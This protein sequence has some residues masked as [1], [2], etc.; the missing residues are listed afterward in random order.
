MSLFGRP[1]RLYAVYTYLG[2]IS[3]C[4]VL[5]FVV[6]V[7]LNVRLFTYL[8]WMVC[9]HH[10]AYILHASSCIHDSCMHVGCTYKILICTSRHKARIPIPR[11]LF[12]GGEI[13]RSVYLPALRRGAGVQHRRLWRWWGGDSPVVFTGLMCQLGV[14]GRL[15]PLLAFLCLH[16]PSVPC[17]HVFTNSEKKQ[18]THI[19][20]IKASGWNICVHT[21]K[22]GVC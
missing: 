13:R 22:V 17:G 18:K 1:Y 5:G 3:V 2:Q 16:S 20:I 6:H 11:F 9:R 7:T 8:L 4:I 10:V 15:E 21:N 12:P 19:R 14:W